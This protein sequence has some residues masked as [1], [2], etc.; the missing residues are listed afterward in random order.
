MFW[1]DYCISIKNLKGEFKMGNINILEKFGNLVK[2]K[3]NDVMIYDD[4]EYSYCEIDTLSSEL[5]SKIKFK[6]DEK[7]R[8][9]ISLD[10]TYKIIVTILAVLKSGNSYVP[11]NKKILKN[12]IND[13]INTSN[14]KLI[15][16]D[17]DNSYENID[18]FIIQVLL[19]RAYLSLNQ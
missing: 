19:V 11:I 2:E 13:I 7:I 16:E 8:I 12:G 14:I 4:R 5:A 10:H 18:V 6:Y 15:I 1:I 9:G 17:S 3:P